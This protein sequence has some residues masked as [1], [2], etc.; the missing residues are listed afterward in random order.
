M[1]SAITAL[2]L[3]LCLSSTWGRALPDWPYEKLLA[4]S[5][6]V[7]IA[8]PML[9]SDTKDVFER[10]DHSKDDYT[11]MNTSFE[12]RSVLKGSP[13][14]KKCEVLH[15]RYSDKVGAVAN[16]ALFVRFRL[17]G[18]SF[19]GQIVPETK[20]G[21]PHAGIQVYR[22]EAKPD[23]LLFLKRRPDGRYEPVTGQ[24]DAALSC[25]EIRDA[26]FDE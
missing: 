19:K 11:G 14:T 25:R 16:G 22:S 17:Q 10:P 1:K 4:E 23:Y 21:P 9:C 6:L 15:F 24:Y 3:L 20:E 8:E 12:I 2:F 5:D 26:G 13:Q 7:V 18:R